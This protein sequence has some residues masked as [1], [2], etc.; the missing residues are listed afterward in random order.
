MNPKK[1][2]EYSIGLDLGT[3]SV[4]W[5]LVD[6]NGDICH[7]KNRPTM[8][9]RLFSSA[10]TAAHTRSLRS[11]RRRLARRRQRIEKLQE[12][13]APEME[14]VDENFFKRLNQS[15]LVPAD[16][17]GMKWV[18]FDNEQEEKTFYKK[19]P[20]IFHLR[21]YLMETPDKADLRW[22]YLALHNI[23]KHR[24]NFLHEGE[25]ISAKTANPNQSIHR[26][27]DALQTYVDNLQQMGIDSDVTEAYSTNPNEKLMVK[28]LIAPDQKPSDKAKDL[29]SAFRPEKAA[30]KWAGNVARAC[31][32]LKVEY[33]KVFHDV[34]PQESITEFSLSDDEKPDAFIDLC[35][36]EAQ[37]LYE[38]IRSVYSAYVLDEILAGQDSL[39][40][41]MV[42]SYE[43]HGK[44]LACV[45][46]L[47]KDERYFPMK[48]GQ[49][50]EYNEFFRGPKDSRGDYDINRL[51]KQSYTFY[52]VG[53][54]PSSF[55][56]KDRCT[57]E[58]LINN[59]K[60]ILDS[61]VNDEWKQD[62]THDTG[63]L[64]YAEM[65]KRLSLD[66][67]KFLAKQKTRSNGAI[68][69]QLHA[70]E[71]EKI[72]DN[73]GQYYPFL[74]KNKELLVKIL[75]SRIPYYVGPLNT[76][77][78]PH[79]PFHKNSN[80]DDSNSDRKFGWAVRTAGKKHEEAYPWNVDEIFDKDETAEN[81]IE[82]MRSTCSYLYGEPVLPRHSLLYEKFCVLNELNGTRIKL[83]SESEFHRIDYSM[84][85]DL[86]RDLFM[87]QKTVSYKHIKTWIKKHLNGA[88][89][90]IKGAQKET[91]FASKLEAWNDFRKI[92]EVDDLESSNCP[93]TLDQIEQVIFWST[94]FEDKSIY[95]HKLEQLNSELEA[96]LTSKQINKLVSL[97]YK[98]WGNLSKKLLTGIYASQ[99]DNKIEK[100]P[101]WKA[102]AHTI[103]DVLENGNP[104][105]DKHNDT[106]VFM[107]I[108]NDK[109]LGFDKAIDQANKEF[110]D[111]QTLSIDDMHG[112][113]ALR[114]TVHQAMLII[115]ELIKV[116]GNRQPKTICIEVTRGEKP[117]DR[118]K[119]TKT[120]F[121]K[122]KEC[123]E[124]LLKDAENVGGKD[125]VSSIV[126]EL[127]KNKTDLSSEKMMLYFMQNGKSLYSGKPLDINR[128]SDYQTDH[129][130]PQM[131][132][133]DDSLDN[134]ALVFQKENQ[135][136]LDNKLL[137]PSIQHRMRST[138]VAL[139]NAGLISEKK[140]RN[141]TRTTVT[142]KQLTGFVNRQ[143]VET[144]Q[145]V[146]F[147]RLMCEQKYPNARVVSV[148]ASVSSG[149]RKRAGLYKSRTL[150]DF[151]HAHDAYL[152]CQD[153]RFLDMMLPR[154][155]NEIDISYVQRW[156]KEQGK[157]DPKHPYGNSGVIVDRMCNG[158]R[159]TNMETGEIWDSAAEKEKMRRVAQY[160]G[161]FLSRMPEYQTGAFWDQ[162]VYSPRD[163]KNAKPDKNGVVNLIP[164][165][166]GNTDHALDV[167]KYG[168]YNKPRIAYCLA[169]EAI[170]KKGR[171]KCFFEGVPCYLASSLESDPSSLQR[172]AETIAQEK[173]C[174]SVLILRH[175]IP[176][177]QKFILDGITYYL[178][179]RA[180][181]SRNY[182][183]PADE[184]PGRLDNYKTMH[185]IEQAVFRKKTD[186]VPEGSI[187]AIFSWLTKK[188]EQSNNK[189]ASL[190]D[191]SSSEIENMFAALS[192]DIQCQIIQSIAKY[193]TGASGTCD[194]TA[195]GKKKNCGLIIFTLGNEL[196][197]ITWIDQSVTGIFERKT[198]F[199]Q[200][201]AA[202]KKSQE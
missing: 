29:A 144:S 73:Q 202:A 26:L 50:K 34:D 6:Q 171:K 191:V 43:Q 158:R 176:I 28:A 146:K 132:I 58:S 47:L 98:G 77:S 128:L 129:I 54:Q 19:F 168:G 186:S 95:K 182:A 145:I 22:V 60:K 83:D 64:S 193:S 175:H 70:E 97:R 116:A 38:A 119:Q 194:L 178:G 190:L 138:W 16:R 40:S 4:G 152:A 93:L 106:M 163:K 23:M 39:S 187:Q 30:A 89:A 86:V 107:E 18:L 71:L 33:A 41:A 177:K 12:I 111:N 189:A 127:K 195:L 59:L 56:K 188:L 31:L 52:V 49:H 75:T 142:P 66:D 165:R 7:V 104:I 55:S 166:G 150:N 123:Y 44:E 184:I 99:T 46:R 103:I 81:F 65:Y 78:D 13:F 105:P 45:K 114:R 157:D 196:P 200:L 130:I 164:L 74:Q 82:R 25:K 85:H 10:D 11:Q 125:Y 137:D 192:Q 149:V 180:S 117:E 109:D 140:F 179:G 79:G 2:T 113:P 183:R 17:N 170:D 141:L 151:H 51:P 102:Q 198:T 72:I 76:A 100:R 143:L 162:T 155:N 9:S 133:K 118:G 126:R 14:K 67:G 37:P 57:Q 161:V 96:P 169:F 139:K 27:A 201:E 131:Y 159:Q 92:L 35:P 15:A 3:G 88:N 134:K 172:Y 148:R 8:G 5:A 63:Q 115:D 135:R 90:E 62:Q 24:G 124:T 122:L 1:A 48:D 167:K 154:W 121:K 94:I 120:R 156:L 147:V 108:I 112:S 68:P 80:H 174:N 61:A 101:G 87:H 69:N 20:T 32:G 173:G 110:A 199:K 42:Q 53:E 36:E 181:G 197:N 21:Q 136:K 185:C 84:K 153:A 91:G 160:Q